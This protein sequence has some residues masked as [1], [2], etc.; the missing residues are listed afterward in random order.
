MNRTQNK[1]LT[2]ISQ[3]L[4]REM[5]QEERKL[6]Y[7][8]LKKLPITITRQKVFGK[9]IADFYIAS[10][11]LVIELDGSQHYDREG[12]ERDGQKEEYLK[13]LKI[14]I[15]RYTNLE[16][17]KNFEGVC[18]DIIRRLDLNNA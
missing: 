12:K 13:S 5:T 16:V 2:P 11:K 3:K 10:K 4:R 14:E 1:V 7:T 6:W 15:V 18:L 9:Y 8:F 17:N